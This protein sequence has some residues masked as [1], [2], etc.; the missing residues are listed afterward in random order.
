MLTKL[1]GLNPRANCTERLQL[2]GEVNANFLIFCF[3]T[4][5]ITASGTRES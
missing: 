3:L 5:E 2:V 4:D 1:R